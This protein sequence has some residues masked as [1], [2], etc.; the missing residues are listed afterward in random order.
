MRCRWRSSPLQLFLP[1][2]DELAVPLEGS[3]AYLKGPQH[4]Y[5]DLRVMTFLKRSRNNFALA[6]DALLAFADKPINLR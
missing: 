1:I 6:G 2:K 3:Q 4:R 5:R